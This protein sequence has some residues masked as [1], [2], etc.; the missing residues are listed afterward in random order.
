LSYWRSEVILH[1]W[2]PP[3]LLHLLGSLYCGLGRHQDQVIVLDAGIPDPLTV[4]G[5]QLAIV[6]EYLLIDVD[7][8]LC[9][10]HD[11]DVLHDS[12]IF[13]LEGNH[14]IGLCQLNR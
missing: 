13:E 6:K 10:Y 8:R 5:K 7:V 11:L 2:G 12:I 1:R 3:L 14:I 9:A 4:I